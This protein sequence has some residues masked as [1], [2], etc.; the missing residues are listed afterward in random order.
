MPTKPGRYQSGRYG[1]I[2]GGPLDQESVWRYP[3]RRG[4]ESQ[5]ATERNRCCGL[6]SLMRGCGVVQC[7]KMRIIGTAAGE[8]RKGLRNFLRSG[9]VHSIKRLSHG[10][11][12]AG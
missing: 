8:N 7:H 3:S 12:R 1:Q 9:A 10:I 4:V 2:S 6:W 5:Q 11:S